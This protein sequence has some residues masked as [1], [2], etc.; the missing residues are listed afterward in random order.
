MGYAEEITA[1]AR[2]LG[3]VQQRC[4]AI[5]GQQQR[6]IEQLKKQIQLLESA[7][8]SRQARAIG[9]PPSLGEF[10]AFTQNRPTQST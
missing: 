8:Q 1:L 5:I 9:V 10:L 2:H 4:S 6:E 3:Q 7:L